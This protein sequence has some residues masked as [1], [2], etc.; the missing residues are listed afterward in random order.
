[1]TQY[2]FDDDH[3]DSMLNDDLLQEKLEGEEKEGKVPM[4][5]SKYKIVWGDHRKNRSIRNVLASG[6][7]LSSQLEAK[8]IGRQWVIWSK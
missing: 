3:Y 5:I 4:S 8:K 1:M 2:Q 6:K 7:K